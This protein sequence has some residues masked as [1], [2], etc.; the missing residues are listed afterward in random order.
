MALISNVLHVKMPV[1]LLVLLTVI[2]LVLVRMCYSRK[3]SKVTS[4]LTVSATGLP[5]SKLQIPFKI[6]FFG[7]SFIGGGFQGVGSQAD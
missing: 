4:Y 6:H 7:N 1:D 2:K 5:V 3:T